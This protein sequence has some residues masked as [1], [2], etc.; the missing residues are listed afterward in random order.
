MKTCLSCKTDISHRRG[1]AVRCVEC[2]Y[3]RTLDRAKEMQT[4]RP[5]RFHK[6][7]QVVC[8]DCNRDFLARSRTWKRC[9]PCRDAHGGHDRSF[10]DTFQRRRAQELGLLGNVSLNIK[11]TLFRAQSGK[12]A[13][14]R[15]KI[16]A[17]VSAH[18]DHIMP[19]DKGGLHEDSNLQVLC[20]TCN[21]QKGNKDPLEFAR[22]NGR[23]F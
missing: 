14:C 2:A 1:P 11:G 22:E 5:R 16:K 9:K 18:L 8:K 7:T 21:L 17:I 12:C 15:M 10:N 13:F 23:L 20:A 3:Q 6:L 4:K 19:L